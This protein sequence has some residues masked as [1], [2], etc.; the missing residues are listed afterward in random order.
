MKFIKRSLPVDVTFAKRVG[1]LQTLEGPVRFEI[2]DA[3]VM[4]S[5]GERW[6]IRRS[7]FDATYAPV[8]PLHAGEEGRYAKRPLAVEARQAEVECDVLLGEGRGSLHAKAGDWIV[9]AEGGQWVVGDAI[10]R[11]TYARVAVDPGD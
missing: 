6:P 11:Q 9:T 10:F 3:L 1:E 8:P 5:V 7:T 4:G 2:G